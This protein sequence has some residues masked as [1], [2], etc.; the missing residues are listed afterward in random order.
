M[1]FVF[2]FITQ[3][4]FRIHFRTDGMIT[5]IYINIYKYMFINHRKYEKTLQIYKFEK[6]YL[7]EDVCG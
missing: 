6:T 4:T 5:N 2:R 1:A 3:N 7:E